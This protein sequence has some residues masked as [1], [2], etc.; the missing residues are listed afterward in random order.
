ME[1]AKLLKKLA[2][3]GAAGVGAYYAADIVKNLSVSSYPDLPKYEE[4]AHMV[5]NLLLYLENE[6]LRIED[7]FE[8]TNEYILEA[9][10]V[11]R[12]YI[13]GRY[14]CQDF[15]MHSILRLQY[16]HIDKIREISPDG[17]QM[18]EDM[19]LGAKYWM[20]EPGSDSMCYWSENH[21]LLYAVAEYLAGQMWYDKTFK[22]DGATGKEHMERGRKRIGYWQQHRFLY[23]YSEYNSSNY[24]LYDVG[25]AAN[26]IQF[27]A[28]EDEKLVEGMR[29]CLDLLIFDVASNMHKY[30]FTAPTGRAYVDNMVGV[31]GDKVRKLID[32]IWGLNDN[33]KRETHQMLINFYSMINAKNPD[34]SPRNLYKIPQVLIEI[35]NDT[36]TRV[37]KSS[38]GMDTSELEKRGYVGHDDNQIMR[39][40]SMEAFT[41]PE[42]I[43]NTITYIDKYKMFNNKFVN[44]F[45]LTN[46]KL[47]NSPKRLRKISAKLNPMPN[48]IAIQRANLYSYQTENYQLMNVQSYRP[49]AFGAQQMLNL[50]NFGENSVVFAVHP[51]KAETEKSARDYPGYWAGF[52]RTPHAVQHENILM[53]MYNIPKHRGFLE[54]YPVPQFSHTYLPE[55]FFDEVITERNYAFARLGDAYLAITGYGSLKYK[56][57]SMDSAKAFKNG[58][59]EIPDK[60][61]DLIQEGN[62]HYWIY[63]L[64]D[65]SEETFEAFKNRI[66]T[67]EIKYQL[68]SELGDLLEY[69]TEGK[70]LSTR[71]AG[72]FNVNGKVQELKYKRFDSEYSITKREPKE[73]LFTFGGH[74]L[75]LNLNKG[76][77]EYD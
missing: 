31:K 19:M 39:Q 6:E 27:A 45:K 20:S 50:V 32:Y 11:A 12:R 47:L 67:N 64:S 21:Q 4:G 63:E 73:I 44:Y 75:Y 7:G 37:I 2:L 41:N 54:L 23:G 72:G 52:G 28:P 30:T 70:K 40:L 61:F 60:K 48:G 76:I 14:D 18:I 13:D 43:Y 49:G 17:A 62:K 22:N 74:K 58:L 29:M 51:A 65:S 36:Q 15:R 5:N 77:R 16:C 25:P 55:A 3:A 34:G 42:V 59:D 35:G 69:R 24:Y 46:L 10:G 71:Y 57:F 56:D 9:L 68:D 1:N 38:H 53:I 66:K 33:Y 8:F 26:F